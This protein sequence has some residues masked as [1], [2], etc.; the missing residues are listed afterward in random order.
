MDTTDKRQ[1]GQLRALSAPPTYAN[2]DKNKVKHVQLKQRGYKLWADRDDSHGKESLKST[3]VNGRQ[4]THNDA[5]CSVGKVLISVFC[6]DIILKL[7]TVFFYGILPCGFRKHS[8]KKSYAWL[9]VI[10]IMLQWNS[11]INF[12]Y[13][14]KIYWSSNDYGSNIPVESAMIMLLLV[15]STTV[16]YTL[17][18]YYFYSSANVFSLGSEENGWSVVPKI[19]FDLLRIMEDSIVADKK[20]WL[21]TTTFLLLGLFYTLFVIVSDFELNM[22]YGFHGIHDFLRNLTTP[23]RFQYYFANATVNFGLGSTVCF[24]CIFFAITRDMV[25]HIE[26]TE[27]AILERAKTRD[28]FYSYHE[29]L[30]QYIERMTATC[31]HWFAFHTC[32][33]IVLVFAVVYEWL[34]LMT[35]KA[36]GP[37]YFHDLLVTQIAG[38]LMITFKFA[39]PFIA[40]SRVTSKFAA[41]YVNIAMKCR[42]QGIPDLLILSHNS[43]FK[44]YGIRI[45]TTAA[46]LAF[47]SSF[48]TLLK[49]FYGAKSSD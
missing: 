46:V 33:F 18:A 34:A 8:E 20:G 39:F 10:L 24:C 25:C 2:H 41:F 23:R 4:H 11:L 36:N 49:V 6:T 16:T 30:H 17:V 42:I 45:N 13:F 32:F 44:L 3:Q 9:S 7:F 40:A 35:R 21:L 26:Y 43:G 15:L 27:N 14:V 28:D 22:F 38:S 48:T 29:R 5:R 47:L 19:K 31:K 12:I 1:Q 37:N